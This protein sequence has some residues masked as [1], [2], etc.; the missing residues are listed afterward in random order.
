MKT[1]LLAG[2]LLLANVAAVADHVA[3]PPAAAGALTAIPVVA[4]LL[5]Y[6]DGEMRK[7]GLWFQAHIVEPNQLFQDMQK[8]GVKVQI[9]EKD[10]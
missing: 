8:M 2:G 1:L 4:C 7:P 10:L 5:Q 9:T 3:E 6:L